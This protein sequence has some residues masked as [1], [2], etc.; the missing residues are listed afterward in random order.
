MKPNFQKF[1]YRKHAV[2]TDNI[3]VEAWSDKERFKKLTG[4]CGAMQN[5]EIID[6][7]YCIDMN[8]L[9]SMVKKFVKILK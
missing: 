9:D 5:L 1:I 2:L 7:H 4:L 6:G 3:I 8:W